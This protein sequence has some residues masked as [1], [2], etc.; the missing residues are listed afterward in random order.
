MYSQFPNQ[1]H[2]V[3]EIN[4]S[5]SQS[6]SPLKHTSSIITG[7]HE[8]LLTPSG[9]CCGVLSIIFSI[10]ITI[11]FVFI[12]IFIG[13][14]LNSS[15]LFLVIPF[16]LLT[17]IFSCASCS[18]FIQN[19]PNEAT[20]LT[21]FGKYKGTIKST[22]FYWTFP[23]YS[24]KKISLRSNNL[25]GDIIQINDKNGNPIRAGCVIVWKVQDTAKALFNVQDYFSFVSVQAESALRNIGCKYPYDKVNEDDICLKSGHEYVNNDLKNELVF[26]LGYAGIEV[27]EARITELSYST[28]IANVMLKRQAADAV[29]AAR[30][31][32][33]NGAMSIVEDAMKA[34]K[35]NKICEF[36]EKDKEE[37]VKNMLIVLSGEAQVTPIVNL[38]S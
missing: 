37:F 24:S 28:E 34:L 1:Q 7:T 38:T 29:V 10:L 36:S 21:F 25:N 30:Q 35:A 33:V 8:I 14:E 17:F 22:G 13:S 4:T 6:P 18:S 27:E 3:E 19:E 16:I 12:A 23:L 11:V 31:T 15:L 9:A 2:P 32:I 20:V 26:R 5:P